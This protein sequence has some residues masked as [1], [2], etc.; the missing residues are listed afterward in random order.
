MITQEDFIDLVRKMRK[1]QK[2]YFKTYDYGVLIESKALEK[3]VDAALKELET[4]ESPT[5]F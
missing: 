1:C 3:Q 4:P 2:D 5:L